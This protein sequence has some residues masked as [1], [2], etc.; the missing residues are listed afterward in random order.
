MASKSVKST[1]SDLSRA[2]SSN[3]IGE[4][5]GIFSAIVAKLGAKCIVASISG[6]EMHLSA[7]IER[8]QIDQRTTLAGKHAYK[9]VA[10]KIDVAPSSIVPIK[11]LKAR[12]QFIADEIDEFHA[13]TDTVVTSTRVVRSPYELGGKTINRYKI[14]SE[15]TIESMSV[16]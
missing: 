15:I 14:G 9:D 8:A 10:W 11:A 3:E 16:E 12:A 13:D 1:K 2:Q 4:I 6:R 7:G 5:I